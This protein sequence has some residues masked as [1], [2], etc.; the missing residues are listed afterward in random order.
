MD[1]W[2]LSEDNQKTIVK[3]MMK[4]AS[5]MST[6]PYETTIFNQQYDYDVT[7]NMYAIVMDVTASFN[8]QQTQNR[9]LAPN[10]QLRNGTG[11]GSSSLPAADPLYPPPD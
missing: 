7:G 8:G 4:I 10:P 5:R 2:G 11:P 3:A 6:F 9:V 1:S